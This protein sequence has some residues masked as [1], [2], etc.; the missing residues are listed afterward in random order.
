MSQRRMTG[1]TQHPDWDPYATGVSESVSEDNE[2]D[3]YYAGEAHVQRPMSS[4]YAATANYHEPSVRQPG[5]HQVHRPVSS[6]PQEQLMYAPRQ[7]SS[8]AHSYQQQQRSPLPERQQQQQRRATH[9]GASST[10]R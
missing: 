3:E 8:Q 6:H 7:Y 2:T 10:L 9:H 4:L 1:G 5:A